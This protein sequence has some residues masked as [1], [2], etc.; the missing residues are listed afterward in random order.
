MPSWVVYDIKG[1]PI[2]INKTV[3]TLG[4]HLQWIY[5]S[6]K[7]ES[8]STGSYYA[9]YIPYLYLYFDNDVLTSWQE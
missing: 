8:T 7:Y 2:K 1:E 9:I 5:E 4:T 3:D 6:E